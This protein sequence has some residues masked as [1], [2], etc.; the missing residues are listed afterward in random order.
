MRDFGSFRN[1]SFCYDGIIH[2]KIKYN[3]TKIGKM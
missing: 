3:L 1:L 2:K